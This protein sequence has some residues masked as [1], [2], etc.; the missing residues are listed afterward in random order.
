MLIEAVE[1]PIRYKWPEGEIL[2]VPGQPVNLPEERA[3]KLLAKAGNKVR[4]VGDHLLQIQV[5]QWVEFA[6]PLFGL[7][8]GLATQED[9]LTLRVDHH[10]VLHD[11]ADIHRDWIVRVLPG[12]PGED[13]L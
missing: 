2:L 12:P 9:G 10:S 6:S 1:A 13:D 5:G 4:L 3:R 8:T 11:W 7:C